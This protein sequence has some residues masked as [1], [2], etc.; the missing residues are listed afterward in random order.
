MRFSKHYYNE[1][2]FGSTD[3]LRPGEELPSG[4]FSSVNDKVS[5]FEIDDGT[6][7]VMFNT[8]FKNGKFKGKLGDVLVHPTLFRYYPE[9]EDVDCDFTIQT[10]LRSYGGT[11][12]SKEK[13]ITIVSRDE[14]SFQDMLVHEIQHAIQYASKMHKGHSLHAAT[15][16]LLMPYEKELIALNKQYMKLQKTLANGIFVDG[17]GKEKN[18]W[19]GAMA[20]KINPEFKKILDDKM[21]AAKF[22]LFDDIPDVYFDNPEDVPLEDRA[23]KYN[24]KYARDVIY[25][26]EYGDIRSKATTEFE[27][28]NKL[29]EK[30]ILQK[31]TDLLTKHF[32]ADANDLKTYIGD[33]RFPTILPYYRA[34]GEAE[35]REV[36][37][38]FTTRKKGM[39]L[40]DPD[41]HRG[42]KDTWSGLFGDVLKKTNEKVLQ[43]NNIIIDGLQIKTTT[44]KF[45]DFVLGDIIYYKNNL[46]KKTEWSWISVVPQ[47]LL[48]GT[49]QFGRGGKRPIS[50][51][52]GWDED[53]MVCATPVEYENMTQIKAAGKRY[54]VTPVVDLND[55]KPNTT[56][57]RPKSFSWDN[58]FDFESSPDIISFGS[59]REIELYIKN[60]PGADV[61]FKIIEKKK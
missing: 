12:D 51:G 23:K 26:K 33:K 17:L 42:I 52:G 40:G 41:I 54:N 5:R 18:I 53:E 61:L 25:T 1:M 32:P 37:S 57:L 59:D 6:M 43:K 60:N 16:V 19:T 10:G 49:I 3:R 35:A 50:F 47:L 45:K 21:V 9:L 28:S 30:T 8:K 58:K 44:K 22:T 36:A 46:Y 7:Q 31:M 4:S 34:H 20:T 48:N 11:H 2:A 13:L 27:A 29:K 15:S 39:S 24:V 56:Y 38:R 55:I 14:D